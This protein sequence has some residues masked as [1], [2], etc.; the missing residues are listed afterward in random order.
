M[1]TVTRQM[2]FCGDWCIVE[3]SAGSLDYAN[4]DMYCPKYPGECEEYLDPREA[5]EVAI[6][7]A[8]AW[9]QDEGNTDDAICIG[10][11]GTGGYTLPFDPH[12]LDEETFADFRQW[13][14]GL[15]EKMEKCE[16]CGSVLPVKDYFVI[17][18]DPLERKFCREYCA[19]QTASEE[20]EEDDL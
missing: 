14:S 4:P 11:G 7:I 12:P 2:P 10:R 15:Y 19:E 8:L 17:P 6:K 5:V 16:R 20:C 18:E 3:I 1:W 9:Q 13:A